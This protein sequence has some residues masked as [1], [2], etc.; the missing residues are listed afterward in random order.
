MTDTATAPPPGWYT[1]PNAPAQ[2]RWWSG[3]GWTDHVQAAPALAEPV[4]VAPVQLGS[5]PLG[6]PLPQSMTTEEQLSWHRDPEPAKS[7]PAFDGFGSIGVAP[8][9]RGFGPQGVQPFA[10]GPSYNYGVVAAPPLEN[11][12][13]KSGLIFSLVS[14]LINPLLI[15]GIIGIV[16]GSQ[17]LSRAR[18]LESMGQPDTRR[19]SATAAVLVGLLSTLLCIGSIVLG[20]TTYLAV[21]SYHHEAMETAIAQ[22]VNRQSGLT[23]TVTCP[24]SEPLTA[25]LTFECTVVG[26]TGG[27]AYADV[28]F[29]DSNGRYSVTYS[30]TPR[31]SASTGDTT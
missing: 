18:Q 7:D 8:L 28:T 4:Q 12:P 19:G 26:P 29:V 5:V 9:T 22:D 3:L 25:G 31:S 10:H 16:K 11:R 2:Q 17:G 20:V 14:L 24:E 27:T 21:H 6:T 1:D 15:I 13:A 30:A 23:A